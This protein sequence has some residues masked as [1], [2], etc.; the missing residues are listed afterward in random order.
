VEIPVE[1]ESSGAATIEELF[2]WVTRDDG[3]TWRPEPARHPRSDSIPFVA[4]EDGRY[5]FRVVARDAA[6]RLQPAPQPG[7]LPE[8]SCIIDT[9][10][11]RL[12]ILYPEGGELVY[13]GSELEIRWSATDAALADAPIAIESRRSPLHPWTPVLE[14]H[15]LPAEGAAQWWPPYV[16]GEFQV[17]VIA[18]DRV[19][20]RRV[21]ELERPLRVVPFDSFRES[22]VLAAETTT[23]YRRFPVFY[24]SPRH[25]PEEVGE[26]E[27][28]ARREFGKWEARR[29][30]DGRS[31]CQFLAEAEGEIEL[32]LRIL[33]RAG[34]EDRPIPGPDTPADL[35][36]LVDTLPPLAQL[37]VADG[38]PLRVHTGGE[39][40]SLAWSIEETD[41][42]PRGARIEASL[43]GGE[44]W[45][46][47]A[48]IDAPASGEGVVEWIPPAIETEDLLLRLVADDRAGNRAARAA[49]TRLRLVDPR[50]NRDELVARHHRR[51]LVLADRGDRRSLERAREE[52]E[53]ALRID[54]EASSAWHDRGVL[55][56]RLGEHERALDS[57]RR[58]LEIRPDDLRL[59]LS[60]VQ[61]HLNLHRVRPEEGI[62]SIEAARAL[63]RGVDK[64][65]IY[66]DPDFREL[67]DRYRRLEEALGAPR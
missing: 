39:P 29:D 6:G 46:T 58:A 15:A 22:S 63:L 57:Y 47:I 40:L 12:E 41:P 26:V 43:D 52:L 23:R 9:T 7:D 54:P 16:D 34:L 5:G 3:T 18:T 4:P 49:P 19:G 27:I 44:R 37:V 42:H 25:R 14:G 10:L 20:N 30:P 53:L 67:L 60:A 8:V 24:R 38:A 17:R 21:V 1:T 36:I 64:V 59:A 35:R 2:L 13:A 56:T 45:Q 32:Y 11:P 66:E 55:E 51:A 33:D 61:G 31:P 62:G 48:E 50:A 65:R 28:W